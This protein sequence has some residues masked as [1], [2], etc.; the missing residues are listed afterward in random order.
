[1]ATTKPIIT[2]HTGVA[3]RD[4][5]MLYPAIDSVLRNPRYRPYHGDIKAPL[6]ERMRY[7]QGFTQRN[8]ALMSA[9]KGEFNI[10]T[11]EKDD[12][13]DFVLNE[14]GR[15]LDG[16]KTIDKLRTEAIALVK[17][18]EEEGA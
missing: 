5:G 12:L 10:A 3:I 16:R 11:A 17:A 13:I 8:A 18:R 15:Q 2:R 4:D 9:E 1:M 14:F 7:L 6:E